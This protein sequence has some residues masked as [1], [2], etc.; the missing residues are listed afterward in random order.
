[1]SGYYYCISCGDGPN[2]INL[3]PYCPVCYTPQ[4]SV[5]QSSSPDY[6][7]ITQTPYA[8]PMPLTS[9][10]MDTITNFARAQD[11]QLHPSSHVESSFDACSHSS[12]PTG[13]I[14][15]TAP[16][17]QRPERPPVYR[18]QC[19]ACGSDNS[20]SMDQGCATCCNHW[21]NTCCHVYDA[22][23]NPSR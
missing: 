22:A 13:N 9:R 16:Y 3:N 5:S 4:P 1:M 8:H 15:Y 23:N 12:L 6:S 20:Y 7:N 2:N 14:P 19:C 17:S 10:S 21:R 18:W 11:N